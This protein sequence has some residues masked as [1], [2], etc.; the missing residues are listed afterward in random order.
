L[1]AEVGNYESA[2]EDF[3]TVLKHPTRDTTRDQ[4]IKNYVGQ[5]YG[6]IGAMSFSRRHCERAMANYSIALD[7][8]ETDP[9]IWKNRAGRSI[10]RTLNVL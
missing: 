7:F 8:N 1:L 10:I 5:V 9:L 6:K 2:L 3:F 4:E